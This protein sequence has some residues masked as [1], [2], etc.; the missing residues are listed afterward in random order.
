MIF[1]LVSTSL[2]SGRGVIADA[3]VLTATG[4]SRWYNYYVEGLA[5]LVQYTGIDGLNGHNRI[6]FPEADHLRIHDP[7]FIPQLPNMPRITN[8]TF[9]IPRQTIRHAI[10]H[11]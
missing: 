3:S 2:A 11:S 5:W 9:S 6:L 4:D 10:L 7:E 1:I 8:N